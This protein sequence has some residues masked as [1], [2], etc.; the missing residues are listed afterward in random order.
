MDHVRK[1]IR[2]RRARLLVEAK[3]TIQRRWLFVSLRD[4]SICGCRCQHGRNTSCH[5]EASE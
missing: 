1:V 2:R 4:G 5:G 3:F